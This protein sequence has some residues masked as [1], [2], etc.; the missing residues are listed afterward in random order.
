MGTQSTSASLHPQGKLHT[1]LVTFQTA[2]EH[3]PKPMLS[4][5][6]HLCLSVDNN[7]NNKKLDKNPKDALQSF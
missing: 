2:T 4:S 6:Q 7:N 1:L 3:L 5:A